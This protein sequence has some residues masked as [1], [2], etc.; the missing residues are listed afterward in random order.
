MKKLF[1]ALMAVATIAMVGCKDKDTPTPTPTPGGGGDDP[2]EEIPEIA[3]PGAGKVTIAIFAKDCPAGAYIVGKN[4]DEGASQ[5]SWDEKDPKNKFEAVKD[6][7]NWYAITLNYYAQ[8][9]GKVL[10]IPSDPDVDLGWSFQ[11]G[12]NYDEADPGDVPEGTENTKILKGD[13]E[14]VYENQGQPKLMNVADNGVI[15][16]E[17][18]NWAQSPTIVPKKL[19]TAWAK[20]NWDNVEDWTWRE[21][22]AK[23]NGVFEITGVWGGKGVNI[24][25]TSGGSDTWYNTDDARFT[26][27]AGAKAGDEVKLTFTSEKLTIGTLNLEIVTPAPDPGPGTKGDVTITGN[28]IPAGWADVYIH[29]WNSEGNLTGDWPGVKLDVTAGQVVKEFTDVTLPV[30]VIF[31]N[32]SGGAGNQTNDMTGYEADATID[33]TANL[34]Q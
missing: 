11:W 2:V 8:F 28:N 15:Y 31:N 14:F 23:G 25:A 10:A 24:A 32:G 34:K 16:I 12:K 18:K 9:E 30:N 19:E 26:I 17:V 13:G 22:E 33:I 20:T 29:A 27:A 5:L 4:G 6:A 1:M 3:A 21:M 7:E